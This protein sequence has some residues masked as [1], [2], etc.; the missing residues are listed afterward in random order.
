[1]TVEI[2]WWSLPLLFTFLAFGLALIFA[3]EPEPSSYF[4]DT[5]A[6][7]ITLLLLGAALVASLVAWL[8]WALA[9]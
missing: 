9:T 6:A 2:G 3:P 1:M 5:G 4:P 8:I 7:V